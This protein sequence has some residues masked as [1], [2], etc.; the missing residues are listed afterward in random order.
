MNI[1]LVRAAAARVTSAGRPYELID[2][3]IDGVA[4]RVFKNAPR[5]LLE[6][7]RASFVH[8]NKDFYVYQTE[9]Y[10]SG[11]T[12]RWAARV[13][14]RLQR[15]GIVPGDRVGIAARNYPADFCV[16]GHHVDRRRCRHDERV[17]VG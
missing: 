5:N 10:S 4:F 1:D 13:A 12:W 8:G 2:A 9:R 3:R 14:R 11:E 7:Y 17:V 15:S 16:H 6:L